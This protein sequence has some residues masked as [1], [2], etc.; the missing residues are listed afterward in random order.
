M[1]QCTYCDLVQL[2]KIPNLKDM[3]GPEYGYKTSVSNLMVN[4][5]KKK[6]TKLINYGVVKN[7]NNILD[8]G[9]NDGTFLNFFSNI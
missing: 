5:L 2:S 1:Y 4:H 3:Y 8:I 6:V 7:N 9:S